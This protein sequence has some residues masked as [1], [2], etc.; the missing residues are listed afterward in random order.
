[1][2]A[3]FWLT[4]AQYARTL[5]LQLRT[6]REDVVH[7]IA[8]MM[9]TARRIFIQKILDWRALTQWEQQLNLCI[10]QLDKNNCHTVIRLILWRAN[11]DRKSVV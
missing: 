8:D 10:W 5:T 6:R 11:L 1:M 7:L 9:N 4:A 2:G 3:N